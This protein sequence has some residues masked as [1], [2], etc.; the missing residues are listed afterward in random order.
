MSFS[1]PVIQKTDT[2]FTDDCAKN[3]LTVAM[4]LPFPASEFIILFSLPGKTNLNF[5]KIE[6]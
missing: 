6:I 4:E 5:I 3:R 1:G 2:L